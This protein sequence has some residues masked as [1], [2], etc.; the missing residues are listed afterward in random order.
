MKKLSLYLSLLTLLWS[1]PAHAIL[2]ADQRAVTLD[3]IFYDAE[4]QVC[5]AS[6]TI[7]TSVNLPASIIEPINRYK[8][9]YEAI[10]QEKDFPWQLIA[11]IH[12]RETSFRYDNPSNGQGAFQLYTLVNNGTH[13]F[14]PGPITSQE[15]RR[16]G[17][18]MVDFFRTKQASNYDA[19]KA[20]PITASS[21]NPEAIKDTLYS[22]N[23]RFYIAAND[24]GGQ[25]RAAQK[26]YEAS[27]YVMNKFDAARQNMQH[28]VVDQG[29]QLDT[30]ERYGAFTIY[31]A[32]AGIGS[33]GCGGSGNKIVDIALQQLGLKEEPPGSD[34]GPQIEKF[35]AGA[36]P[37]PWC[38][39]FVSWVYNEAGA[40]FTDGDGPEWRIAGAVR[41]SDYIRANGNWTERSSNSFNPQPGD[42]VQFLFASSTVSPNDH[43]GIVERVEGTTLHT[44]EGNS[45]NQVA[46]RQYQ[47]YATNPEIIGWGRM[48]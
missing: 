22:Y 14:P 39:D 4:S 26:D 12:Y 34:G 17:G 15:F 40:G 28:D 18:I 2:E 31:A 29:V 16:Q 37:E 44:I 33:S 25:Y 30:D 42:V 24:P 27:S 11:A 3:H 13:T 36:G 32:L 1:T 41:L 46:R 23:G 5:T 43:V 6:S 19:H 48:Q 9:D 20:P 47:N 8:A 35:Q 7:P 10:G 21:P 38:A 45:G